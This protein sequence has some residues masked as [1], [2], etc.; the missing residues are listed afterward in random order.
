MAWLDTGDKTLRANYTHRFE[1]MKKYCQQAF[2]K[3]GASLMSMRT[4]EDYVKVLQGFFKN[5]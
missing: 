4:N 2:R 3:S 1:Q 5:R